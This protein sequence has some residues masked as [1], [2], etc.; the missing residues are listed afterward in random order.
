MTRPLYG[1]VAYCAAC[2]QEFVPEGEVES[3]DRLPHL[4]RF[5]S[6]DNDDTGP[7]AG[8]GTVTV[9]IVAWFQ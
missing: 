5:L 2:G 1:Y 8:V 9:K 6:D 7:C 4:E 3:G